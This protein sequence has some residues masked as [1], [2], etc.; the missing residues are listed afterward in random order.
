MVVAQS[1][2]RSAWYLRR[3]LTSFLRESGLDHADVLLLG[4]HNRPP[5]ERILATC[6]AL[7]ERGLFRHLA[8]SGHRRPLFADLAGDRT[9]DLFHLRYNAGHRGAEEEVFAKLPP[10]TE[11]PGIVTYTATCWG[12]LLKPAGLPRE[13]P[14][15]RASDC[16][17]FVLTNPAVDVCLCGPRSRTEMEE[18]LAALERGPLSEDELA[19][20]RRMGD[21]VAGRK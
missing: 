1:Y 7:K 5:S 21:R 19:W 10:L 18:A 2:S 6:A 4:W 11:R 17:R 14:V 16:Y 15:P 20:M 12:K 3:S 9:Y 8:L 13:F